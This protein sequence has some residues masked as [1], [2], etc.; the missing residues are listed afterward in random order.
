[1]NVLWSLK[2]G[3]V[4]DIQQAMAPILPRAY[5]TI[6]TIMDRL[7]RKGVVARVKRGRAYLY[8]PNLSA[9]EARGHAVEQVV[10]GFFD[11]SAEALSAHLSGALHVL[12]AT[13][14]WVAAKTIRPA[15]NLGLQAPVTPA[16]EPEKQTVDPAASP[17]LGLDTTLL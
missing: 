10:E 11:G 4:R 8:L 2:Q 15:A 17:A 12:K 9:E 1:M 14:S 6:M 3:T 5:T 16:G 7:T 13:S